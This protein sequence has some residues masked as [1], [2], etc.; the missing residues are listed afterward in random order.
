MADTS[1]ICLSW[2]DWISSGENALKSTSYAFLP[3]FISLSCENPT[4]GLSSSNS[5]TKL[6]CQPGCSNDHTNKDKRI[7]TIS[8]ATIITLFNTTE[9][10]VL[11]GEAT[12]KLIVRIHG[13]KWGGVK[14]GARRDICS[15]CFGLALLPGM[16]RCLKCLGGL[17]LSRLGRRGGRVEAQCW[18]LADDETETRALREKGSL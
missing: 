4:S 16:S 5:M 2:W 14:G 11:A 7:R 10:L 12:H 9:I 15:S 1:S 17:P 8:K 6:P 18:G 13:G 3:G